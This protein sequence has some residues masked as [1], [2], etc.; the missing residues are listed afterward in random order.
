MHIVIIHCAVKAEHRQSFL[1]RVG[2]LARTTR[3]EAGN[4]AYGCFEDPGAPGRMTFI[5]E[6]RTRA[7]IDAHMAQPYTQAFLQ[8][9]LPML[10]EPPSMRVFEVTRSES[11][12]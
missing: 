4:I 10:A 6:W 9:A 2:D 7:D 8:A 12:M 11:L 5:E 1:D 3:A